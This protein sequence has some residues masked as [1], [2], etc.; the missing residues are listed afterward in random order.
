MK[1]ISM[2]REGGEDYATPSGGDKFGYGLCLYLNEDQ[3]E[4]LGLGKALRPGTQVKLQAQALVTTSAASLERDGDDK[5]DDIT[6]SL[7]IT[8]LGVEVGTVRRDAAAV[9][10]GEG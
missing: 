7:Q 2:K 6:V 8:D 4:A 9:L 3:C 5:G 1:L 10:Y